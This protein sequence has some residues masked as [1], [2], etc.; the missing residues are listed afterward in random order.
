[1]K[2]DAIGIVEAAYDLDASDKGWL[3]GLLEKA[4]PHLDRGL[5]VMVWRS[6]RGGRVTKEDVVALG[7]SKRAKQ[8]LF[9]VAASC[10]E[11]QA[12]LMAPARLGMSLALLGLSEQ[13][14]LRWPAYAKHLHPVGAREVMGAIVADPCGDLVGFSALSPDTAFPA[15]RERGLWDRLLA[16]VAAGSRL[17]S[18]RPRPEEAV[19]SPS[20]SVKHAEAA[21]TSRSARD[22]LRDAVRDVDRARSRSRRDD[23]RA[24]DLWQGLVS[25]RWS[26]IERFESDGRR[27]YVARRNDPDVAEPLV[28]TR[29]ER[30]VVAYAAMGHP[31]KLIAYELGLG[32]STVAEHRASAMRKLGVRSVAE[33]VGLRAPE[34]H[35]G[36]MPP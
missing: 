36:L 13:E 4:A 24:L 14:A 12:R 23:D 6:G 26:L 10:P 11:E 25:G 3:G 17:R 29:R 28:L 9:S 34:T 5:G 31:L 27:F 8:A 22:A 19:L 35:A 33:L 7:V 30:Q 21:A 1:M 18:R 16:H 15:P 20:G 32:V 2:R